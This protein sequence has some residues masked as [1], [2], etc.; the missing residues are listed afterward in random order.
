MKKSTK[1]A[2]AA[3]AAAS[4]LLGGAGSLAYWTDQATITGSSITSGHL[5]LTSPVCGQWKFADGTNLG[6]G[7]IVPGDTVS[8]TCTYVVDAAGKNLVATFDVTNPAMT[9]GTPLDAVLDPS[10]TYAVRHAGVTGTPTSGH[11]V[12]IS[13]G[14]TVTAVV[15]VAFPR[16]SGVDNSTNIAT[17]VTATL[18]NIV[19][20]ATQS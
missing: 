7:T 1:G 14:D 13:A 19:V 11:G 8:E 16:G 9:G 15:T 5:K 6:N 3:G 20:T 10:A 4:L 2:L 18:D 12:T 17:G